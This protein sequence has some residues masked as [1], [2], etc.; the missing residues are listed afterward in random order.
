LVSTALEAFGGVDITVANAG[1]LGLGSVTEMPLATWHETLHTNLSSIFYLSRLS[2]PELM[3]RGGG[4]ILVTSSIGAHKVFPNHPAYCA[5]K[6]GALALARQMAREYAPKVRV[7]VL[8]PGPVDTPLIWDSAKAFENPE[9]AVQ[10]AADATLIGRLGRPADIASAA[11]FFVSNE[12]AWITGAAL[13]VDG[14]I[15]CR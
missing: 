13:T 12:A 8:C 11:L 4:S 2:I 5:T 3:K 14:G 15:L 6:A 1:I 10:D 9:R 7:N